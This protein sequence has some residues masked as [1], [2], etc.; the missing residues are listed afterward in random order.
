[1]IISASRR[2]DIPA[3]YAQWFMKRLREGFVYTRNPMNLKQ[4]SHVALNPE[5]V[6]CIVFWTKNAQPMLKELVTI[7]AMG[8]PYY[9]QFTV[10]PYGRAVE[11]GL[12]SKAE[13]METFQKLSDKIGR[14]RIIWRYDPII[15]SEAFSVEYHLETFEK[16][17]ETLSGY[18]DQCIFSFMDLYSKIQK[19]IQGIADT[20][21]SSFTR[22]QIVQG[23]SQIARSHQL[24]LAACSENLFLNE[25]G[26]K[27]ASC[28]DKNR[29][30]NIIG[31]SLNLKK[32]ANQRP[33]CGCMESVDI[34][35]YNSCGHS[36]L[37]CYASHSYQSLELNRKSHDPCSPLLI[38]QLDG[39][40]IVT[41][42][43]TKSHKIMQSILFK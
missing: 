41:V 3:F 30:E 13:I 18:T 35:A 31:Y 21:V 14:Q 16:M 9:F 29:I 7:D 12:P 23:F 24:E 43:N 34:G 33:A 6:D 40:D 20:K 27:A 26:I 5:V 22:E 42:K 38:S 28:I 2:T 4:V 15:I 8:F 1:M 19:R 17:C 36:C 39:Q 32:D 37:Y 10:T 11:G 25:Y